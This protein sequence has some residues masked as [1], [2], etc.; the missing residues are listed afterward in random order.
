[1]YIWLSYAVQQNNAPWNWPNLAQST[2]RSCPFC[3]E[4]FDGKA[5]AVLVA[6]GGCEHE[7]P[8]PWYMPRIGWRH[9]F[10]GQKNMGVLQDLSLK[11]IQW[12]LGSFIFLDV[13]YTVYGSHNPHPHDILMTGPFPSLRC[14]CVRAA[15]NGPP[16]NIW[17]MRPI[18]EPQ[19]SLECVGKAASWI[20]ISS[21][22]WWYSGNMIGM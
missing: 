16:A 14:G 22:T 9:D 20:Q 8:S 6:V 12:D 19:T 3:S 11:A 13:R 5:R 18:R 17:R 1:M 2:R 21:E 4:S 7:F 15:F 10:F